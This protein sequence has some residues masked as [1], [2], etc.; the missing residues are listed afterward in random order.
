MY[1][2][3][4]EI[5][6]FQVCKIKICKYTITS[7]FSVHFP[8]MFLCQIFCTI[9]IC[10]CKRMKSF[11]TIAIIYYMNFLKKYISSMV[12]SYIKTTAL[13]TKV[14]VEGSE[15]VHIKNWSIVY[16][17]WYQLTNILT[18]P[19]SNINMQTPENEQNTIW[20][21]GPILQDDYF[22][23]ISSYDTL[24]HL[25]DVCKSRWIAQGKK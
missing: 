16:V 5:K 12:K 15:I 10:P 14:H 18:N 1:I 22:K 7:V 2:S 20:S 6:A 19:T 9:H 8:N 24:Q 4:L 17:I 25:N 11:Y 23:V 21:F 13:S 3:I